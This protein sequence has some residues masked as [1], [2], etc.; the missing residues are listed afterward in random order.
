MN[1]KNGCG[2]LIAIV[3][4]FALVSS[5][6]QSCNSSGGGSYTPSATSNNNSFEHRYVKERVKLEG[7]SDSEAQ[8]A[9]DAIIKF[10]EAQKARK[11]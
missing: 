5:A 4:G 8:Q 9:A 6:V 11:R 7:Y 2:F 3:F 10:H 1:D